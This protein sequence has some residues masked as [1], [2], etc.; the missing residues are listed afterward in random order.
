[1]VHFSLNQNPNKKHVDDVCGAMDLKKGRDREAAPDT[2]CTIHRNLC[3]NVFS[4][5]WC[6]CT[7]S[8]ARR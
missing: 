3:M 4:E 2:Q 5:T 6:K 1:M 8:K 7:E